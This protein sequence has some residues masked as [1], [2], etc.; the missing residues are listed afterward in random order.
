MLIKIIQKYSYFFAFAIGSFAFITSCQEDLP[1]NISEI[2][3]G[4]REQLGDEIL[5]FVEDK[6]LD[7]KVIFEN[8][9][10]FVYEYLQGIYDFATFFP[11]EDLQSPDNNRWDKNRE[12]RIVIINQD[13]V[14]AF[15]LPGGHFIISTGMLKK[16]K[17]EFELFFIMNFEIALMEEKYLLQSLVKINRNPQPIL[18]VAYGKSTEDVNRESLGRSLAKITYDP[19]EYSIKKLDSIACTNICKHST[20]SNLGLLKLLQNQIVADDI[21]LITRPT[22]PNREEYIRKFGND[23]LKCSGKKWGKN[24]PRFFRDSIIS[25]LP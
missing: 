17:Y 8:E 1:P 18:E 9:Y 10:P 24:G 12:W 3:K 7:C 23:Q 4:D 2:T 25:R 22:Y 19:S 13:E 21:W 15:C 5:I 11:R 6:S 20:F 14:K 16:I